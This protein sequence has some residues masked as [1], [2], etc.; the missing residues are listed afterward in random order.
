MTGFILTNNQKLLKDTSVFFEEQGMIFEDKTHSFGYTLRGFSLISRKEVAFIES[1]DVTLY[2][3]GSYQYKGCI[4]RDAGLE[5]IKNYKAKILKFE[6]IRGCWTIV[7]LQRD[8]HPIVISSP[9]GQFFSYY[10]NN[11]P[12]QYLSSS[13]LATSCAL[14]SCITLEPIQALGFITNG[15]VYSNQTYISGV[16]RL[17]KSTISKVNGTNI[18]HKQYDYENSYAPSLRNYSNS[19]I[20]NWSDALRMMADSGGIKA[21]LSAGLDTR[22]IASF[23]SYVDVDH[24]FNVNYSSNKSSK[25]VA[26]SKQIAEGEGRALQVIEYPNNFETSDLSLVNQNLIS[27]DGT[28]NSLGS[29]SV[30]PQIFKKKAE[31]SEFLIGGHGGELLR[32]YWYSTTLFS[33]LESFVRRHFVIVGLSD[34]NRE[35]EEDLISEI[36]ISSRKSGSLSQRD[37]ANIYYEFRM[38]HWAGARL[39]IL[40]KYIKKFSPLNDVT[41]AKIAIS[42]SENIKINSMASKNLI[43]NF[44]PTI[45]DYPSQYGPLAKDQGIKKWGKRQVN[46]LKETIKLSGLI[47]KKSNEVEIHVG[48]NLN[49][50]NVKS[51]IEEVL[52]ICKFSGTSNRRDI[53]S[54]V[55]FIA[56]VLKFLRQKQ[57]SIQTGSKHSN[58]SSK[59]II[60]R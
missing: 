29:A 39:S 55:I 53:I 24:C 48:E 11:C 3:A 4:G 49:F 58:S 21:D 38:Y 22:I 31:G 25:D 19:L 33:S 32:E 14:N 54:N 26:I 37:L 42:M 46:I 43:Y 52:D 36:L 40:N 17:P 50:L 23:L 9:T 7:V 44:S 6:E 15:T 45:Y 2:I 12:Y 20:D 27:Y 51:E 1:D 16:K 60:A 28:R 5:I 47:Q 35:L 13:F 30:A 8:L 56:Y 57:R 18:E 41:Q 10:T 34:L 59:A